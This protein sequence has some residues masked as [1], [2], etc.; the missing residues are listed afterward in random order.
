MADESMARRLRPLLPSSTKPPIPPPA[1]QL[2]KRTICDGVR[3]ICGPCNRYRRECQYGA[4]PFETKPAAL[5]WKQNELQERIINRLRLGQKSTSATLQDVRD[6]ELLLQWSATQ[7]RDAG[8]GSEEPTSFTFHDT[9]SQLPA[10]GG[11]SG[12]FSTPKEPGL[13]PTWGDGQQFPHRMLRSGLDD[14]DFVFEMSWRNDNDVNT[15]SDCF[16]YLS[17]FTLPVSR[18]TKVPLDNKLLN[19]ILLLFWTWDCRLNQVIDR[20][21]F[22]EDLRTFDPSV[23]LPRKPCFC[24]PFL[25]N[26]ILAC[27]CLYTTNE[28]TFLEPGDHLTRGA[29]F[30]NEAARL[31]PL[32][33]KTS[34][35]PVAQGLAALMVYEGCLGNLSRTLDYMNRYYET[36]RNLDRDLFHGKWQANITGAQ[37]DKIS[38][39]LSWIHWGLY[40]YEWKQQHALGRPKLIRKPKAPKLWL[41]D[42][43]SLLP[44]ETA[45]HWWFP[46]P[47]SLTPQKSLKREIFAAEREFTEIMEENPQRASELYKKLMDWKFS[48]PNSLRDENVVQPAVILLHANLD[49]VLISLL[50]PFDAM[51]RHEFGSIDPKETSYSHAQSMMSTVWMF[52]ALYTVRH[53]FIRACQALSEMSE[54][55]TVARDVMAPLQSVIA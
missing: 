54:R 35:I 53:E 33:Y 48:L 29:A 15:D 47:L 4:A 19:H 23:E 16:V 30:A 45:D 40:M 50:R 32:E 25:V 18:W 20:A 14:S 41:D 8:H 9:A 42:Q 46:Y 17:S 11:T 31:L 2:P 36:Y 13:G 39:A 34:S 24:S 5:K 3:P 55:F 49:C 51:T 21:L 10:T 12:L 28:E 7:R 52:R 22:E 27:G 38:R 1:I 43:T 37:K 44:R 26:A 6:A